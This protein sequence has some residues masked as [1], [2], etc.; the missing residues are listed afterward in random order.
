MASEYIHIYIYHF[1]YNVILLIWKKYVIKLYSGSQEDWSLY[2]RTR[3]T[4]KGTGPGAN[5]LRVSP[6]VFLSFLPKVTVW[7]YNPD[8]K[9]TDPLL[10]G[11]DSLGAA[12]HA[13][14]MLVDPGL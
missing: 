1:A 4:R 3:G 10:L 7:M 8:P 9:R 6:N 13:Q 12:E 11:C 5:H 2:L 14:G